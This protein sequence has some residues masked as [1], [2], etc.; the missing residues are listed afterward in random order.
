VQIETN[1]T[2]APSPDFDQLRQVTV[3]CSPKA[4]KVNKALIPWI[5]AYKYV[6]DNGSVGKD[7]LPLQALD[8][9]ASPFVARPHEDFEGPVYLQPADT[10]SDLRNLIN[11][12]LVQ[13]NCMQFGFIL[14]L[15]IHK[16][17]GVA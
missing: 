15:Q 4:G 13:N 6:L 5:S 16:I 1:G 2:L 11:L 17:L 3:V 12:Q 14:Q 10:K 9:T 8:H 7:G